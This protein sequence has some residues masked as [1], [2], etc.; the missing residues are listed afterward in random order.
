LWGA[1]T[2]AVNDFDVL[3]VDRGGEDFMAMFE[4]TYGA[5]PLT[6]V[7]STPSGGQ[8]YYWKHRPGL[9]LSASRLAPNID[10]RTTGGYAI[11]KGPGYRTLVDAE[12]AP[13]P[14]QMLEL[15]EEA[16]E[17]RWQRFD[18]TTMPLMGVVSEGEAE[19]VTPI[20][21]AAIGEGFPEPI[22]Y[23]RNYAQRSL[24]NACQELRSCPADSH[25]RNHLL[26]ALAYKMGR[27]IVRGWIR[28]GWVETY[29]W[30]ACK[31]C[32]LLDDPDDGPERT[33]RTMV[34]GIEAGMLRPYDDIRW[35]VEN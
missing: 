26:N 2:G 6:R 21:E 25:R 22:A 32:G 20:K 28:R 24:D 3:D 23:E 12:I 33:W 19:L 31:A 16:E 7:V 13:W 27:Q 5:L 29:L 35:R 1:P 4:A 14:S 17:Q 15:L 30:K 9:K 18:A 11:V 34:S 8:H 10:I